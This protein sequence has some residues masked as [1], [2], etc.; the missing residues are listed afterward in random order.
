MTL[1]T[2]LHRPM[3][4]LRLW[5]GKLEGGGIPRFH[6]LRIYFSI[7]SESELGE[8]LSRRIGME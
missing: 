4:T 7:P 1:S 8:D 6:K 5:F 2:Q 3:N